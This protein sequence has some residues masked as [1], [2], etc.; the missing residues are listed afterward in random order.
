[1]PTERTGAKAVLI[2]N[3]ILLFGGSDILQ[4]VTNI[5]MYNLNYI[6]LTKKQ[7]LFGT[8]D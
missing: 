4:T 7:T 5:D 8:I 6:D 3:K 2:N 1:M